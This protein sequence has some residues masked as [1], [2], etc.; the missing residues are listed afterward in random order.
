[1]FSRVSRGTRAQARRAARMLNQHPGRVV[2]EEVRILIST[3][4]DLVERLRTSA[5]PELRRLRTQTEAALASAKDAIAAG[6]SQ[7]L[8]RAQELGESYIRERPWSSLGI[9]ALCV[10]AIGVWT[11][12]AV[13][14]D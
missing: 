9:V 6:G 3:V 8:D 1:M 14:S 11:G 5:D 4:D 2:N 7:A 12:R 13:T 10:L